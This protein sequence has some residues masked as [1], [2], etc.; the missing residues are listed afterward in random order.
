[1]LYVYFFKTKIETFFVG[2]VSLFLLAPAI[3]VQKVF[4]L[5]HF[6]FVLTCYTSSMHKAIIFDFF[7]VFCPDLSR[8]WF[9]R[10]A[11]DFET[12]LDSF[13]ALCTRS[14]YGK[15]SRDGFFEEVSKLAGTTVQQM[16]EGLES[17]TIINK[18]LVEFVTSIK[19]QNYKIA[20]LSNGTHEWTL[21]VI[22]DHGLGQLFD[23]V[24]LSGDL[25]IVKPNPEIYQKTLDELDVKANDALFV[26]DREVNIKGAEACGIQSI[27]F[28]TTQ[29]FIEDFWK[30]Q[31][32]Q[33]EQKI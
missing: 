22:T 6:H 4:K 1:M 16:T 27:L 28:T 19:K 26:D 31:Q 29:K 9:V 17:L 13:Q 7:G 32:N 24:V 12:K 18:E 8:D 23:K 2:L 15:L 11:P 20:C 33:E 3:V 25:G 10:T 14:D 30:L 5:K 21:R